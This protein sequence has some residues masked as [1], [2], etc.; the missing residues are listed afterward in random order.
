MRQEAATEGER[1]QG[2]V[3]PGP[4]LEPGPSRETVQ[5]Q[6]EKILASKDFSRS[7]RLSRFLRYV[8]EQTIQGQGERLKEYTVGT[9]VFDRNQSYDPRTDPIVRV[10][11]ARL[12]S[13]LKEYYGTDG[14]DDPVFIS[15]HK[16]SYIPAFLNQTPAPALEEPPIPASPRALRDWKMVA[17]VV[18][19]LLVA[20]VAYWAS[21]LYTRN[22]SLQEQVEAQKL[23]TRGPE[24]DTIWRQF[25][26]AETPTFVVF[27]S[28]MFFASPRHSLFLRRP[29]L[30]DSA[31]LQGDN[32]YQVLREHFGPLDGPRYDYAEMGEA[33]ALQ[34]LTAFFSGRGRMLTALPAHLATWES[35]KDGNIIFLG[36]PRLNPLLRKLPIQQDFEWGADNNIYNRNMHPGERQTYTTSDHRD[37]VSY[38]VIA[39][40]P[41]LRPN[42]RILLLTAHSAPGTMAAVDYVTSLESARTMAEKL[43]LSTD[44]DPQSYQMLLRVFVDKGAPVK[45]EYVTHHLIRDLPAK[46]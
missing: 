13:K 11:A 2:R 43:Q 34:R 44:G 3:D 37:Q 24:F 19:L 42:R 1:L 28:P 36:A 45:T 25:S 39:C 4:Q 38:A 31:S 16:G 40:F 22:L 26:S 18:A 32:G 12:R 29:D 10:E 35:I 14:R 33:I 9:E 46:K 20:G 6:L 7:E 21:L 23:P 5:A 8:V 15:F 41:G 27:G 30:N 17:L